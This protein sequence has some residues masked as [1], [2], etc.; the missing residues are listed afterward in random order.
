MGNECW[1]AGSFWGAK[2]TQHNTQHDDGQHNDTQHYGQAFFA[3][4]LTVVWLNVVA[5]TPCTSG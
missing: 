1:L 2:S 3:V 5:L 4:M